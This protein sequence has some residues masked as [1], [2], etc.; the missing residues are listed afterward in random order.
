MSD[1]SHFNEDGNAHMVDVG[2]KATTRRTAITA[3]WISMEPETLKLIQSGGHKKGD[4]L[5]IARIA[6]IMAAKRTSDLVPLCHPLMLTHVDIDLQVDKTHNRVNCQTTVETSGQTGVEMEAL[7]A[8]Q[9]ALLTIYDMCKAVD[10]GMVM[11][12]VRL[13]E[14]KGGKSGHWRR[15]E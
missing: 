14:K 9:I 1:F 7:T 3:G 10:R 6:G 11:G 12:D 8:T 15:P 13:L 5:G 2:Q 4:V